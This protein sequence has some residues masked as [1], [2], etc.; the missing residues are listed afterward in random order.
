M[1]KLSDFV[2][3]YLESLKVKQV[4]MLSGGGIMHLVDS[5]GRSSVEY[6]CCHHEQ[7][8]AIA[9][10]AYAMYKNELGVC[11]V[12]TG[13]GGTNALTATVAS[14]VDSTP[15]MFLSGQVKREDFA[16]LRE[17]RQFGAQ[18]NDIISM[19]RPVTKYAASVLQPENILYYLQKAVYLATHGRKGPVWLDIPL[20]V[21][22]AV[23][24]E[25]ELREFHASGENL[26]ITV[27]VEK[28]DKQEE[29]QKAVEETCKML[30]GAKRPLFLIGHGVMASGSANLFRQLQ[31][32]WKIPVTATWRALDIMDDDNE[33]FFGS[34]G[35][36]ANRYANLITQGTDC[37]IVLGSRLDNMITAFN[38]EHFAYRSKKMIVDIDEKEVLKLHMKDTSY[39][40]CNVYDYLDLLLERSKSVELP[41]YNQWLKFCRNTKRRFPL[42]LEQQ[43]KAKTA[44]DLYQVTDD[45]SRYCDKSDVIVV[46]STSRCN[47]AGHMAMKHKEGQ[48]TISSM[49]MGSMGFAL[50]SVVGAYFASDKKRI[51]MLEGDGS[52]QLNIQELQ[53][54]CTYQINA[55]MFIWSN[56]GYAAITKM[57]ERNFNGHYVG[58]NPESGVIMP[59]LEKLAEAYGIPYKKITSDLEIEEKVKETMEMAGAVICEIFGDITFDEIPKCISSVDERGMRISAALENPYP[60]LSEK[61]MEEIWE[62]LPE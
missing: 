39:V 58:S 51:V 45:I 60:F 34:P 43:E 42:L 31:E 26:E 21:Q 14:Y 29:I 37:L 48:R 61:E 47:T 2:F 11:L 46:S 32:R 23:I 24:E 36:Q 52:L 10:Q 1:M 44:A 13:P 41:S 62:Q 6:I 9:S 55:K 7:A 30:K 5:L 28:A 17:V 49:G 4:F 35:L 20:D 15:V 33:Y 3:Q 40:I 8:S 56:T 53:T 18:E 25:T 50:P 57:Q 19:A 16:S 12:T 59:N 54:I 22:A 27:E 38:E